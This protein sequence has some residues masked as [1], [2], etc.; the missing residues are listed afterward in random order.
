[1]LQKHL[2]EAD[3]EYERATALNPSQLDAYG[4]FCF[5]GFFLGKAEGIPTCLDKVIRLSPRDPQLSEWLALGGFAYFMLRQNDEAIDW[6]R[7]SLALSP[8]YPLARACLA[9]ALALSGHDAEAHDAMARY[10]ALPGNKTKSIMAYKRQALSDNPGY[11]AMREH[12]YDGL[13][14]AGMP[15]Q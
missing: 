3:A 4:A 1:V 5:G 13:R 7:R 6:E 10:L 12:L 9:A 14:K 15:E 2:E 8:N 11:L